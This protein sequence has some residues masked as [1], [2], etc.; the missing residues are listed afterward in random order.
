MTELEALQ[1][2]INHSYFLPPAEKQRLLAS[3]KDMQPVI[4][5][6]LGK[7][8]AAEK[9]LSIKKNLDVLAKIQKAIEHL[10]LKNGV[11]DNFQ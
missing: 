4:I 3:L 5:N 9:R 8:L 7:I 6:T 2:L 10:E 11:K 1:I